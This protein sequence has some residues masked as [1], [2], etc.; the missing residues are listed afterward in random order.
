MNIYINNKLQEEVREQI[1]CLIDDMFTDDA[2]SF[3][4]QKHRQLFGSQYN[5]FTAEQCPIQLTSL[6]NT[7]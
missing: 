7:T 1:F 4:E 3:V 5:H 2:L 6:Y